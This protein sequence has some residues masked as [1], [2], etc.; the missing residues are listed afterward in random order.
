MMVERM[1]K[2]DLTILNVFTTFKIS[3]IR[4]PYKLSFFKKEFHKREF[5]VLDV[6]CG[7]NSP[8]ITK[9]W[10][11]KCKYHGLDKELYNINKNASLIVEK[12]YSIDLE[13]S[14]LAE[15]ND[16]N[17]D[18][19]IF[20]HVIEHLKNGH[21]VI[22]RLANKLKKGGKIYIEF[23]SE[24]SLLLPTAVST[25]N[26]YDDESHVKFYTIKEIIRTIERSNLFIIKAGRRRDPFGIILFFLYLPL[27]FYTLLK[28][29]KLNAKGL[30]DICG[31]ANFV[32]AEKKNVNPQVDLSE[33]CF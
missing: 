10:F 2:Y 32:Y 23:P 1:H 26:F 27:Q 15:I 16:E 19:I 18:A 3:K 24:R 22:K 5:K 17:Y 7:N 13:K 30:W 21:N 11:S 6:G 14:E 31:F 25:L 29:H 20:A 33:K 4:I 8:Q 9:Y 28:Y 12:F